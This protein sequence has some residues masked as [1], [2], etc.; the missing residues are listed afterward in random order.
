M[1]LFY[2]CPPRFKGYAVC[3]D[4]VV[5]KRWCR[6]SRLHLATGRGSR[7]RESY[8]GPP[9][10]NEDAGSAGRQRDQP[11]TPRMRATPRARHPTLSRGRTMLRERRRSRQ[12]TPFP[13]LF[14]QKPTTRA[15]SR[16]ACNGDQIFLL[17][18]DD[19]IRI[20]SLSKG[21]DSK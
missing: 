3:D 9:I 21:K 13:P 7:R 15:V 2:S 5:W 12:R 16:Y 18:L 6:R 11:R 19:Y 4:G 8:R 14:S 1:I 20:L 17:S 10:T